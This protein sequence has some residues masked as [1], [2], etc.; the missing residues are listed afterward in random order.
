MKKICIK[1]TSCSAVDGRHYGQINGRVGK[2]LMF[3]VYPYFHT[4]VSK[5]AMTEPKYVPKHRD[6][7]W[8]HREAITIKRLSY[9]FRLVAFIESLRHDTFME[10]HAVPFYYMNAILG[11]FNKYG[12]KKQTE[13]I[14]IP[15]RPE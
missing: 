1:I 2:R 13:M 7:N 6:L 10:A 11:E 3:I 14:L 15:V 12:H 9:D 4:N 5:N 8:K